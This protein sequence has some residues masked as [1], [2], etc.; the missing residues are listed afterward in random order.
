M[1]LIM[2]YLT[3]G[4]KYQR[5]DDYDDYSSRSSRRDDDY[6][7]RSSRPKKIRYKAY[8]RRCGKT[9]MNSYDSVK[10]AIWSLSQGTESGRIRDCAMNGGHFPEIIQEEY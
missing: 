2:D 7:S 9:T 1:G 4:K 3:G 6:P 10:T 8:C 5:D